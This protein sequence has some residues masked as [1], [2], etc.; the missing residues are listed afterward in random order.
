M[1]WSH[2]IISRLCIPCSQKKLKAQDGKSYAAENWTVHGHPFQHMNIFFQQDFYL[3]HFRST[4]LFSCFDFLPSF[5]LTF[6]F[7]PP[8]ISNKRK[9]YAVFYVG[10]LLIIQKRK[11]I[12]KSVE[13]PF[14]FLYPLLMSGLQTVLF[15]IYFVLPSLQGQSIVC[16]VRSLICLF[17]IL[18]RPCLFCSGTTWGTTQGQHQ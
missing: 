6:L 3:L 9:Q 5:L 12:W 8:K 14:Y 15:Q 16:G 11:K 4:T 10:S 18:L 1:H 2:H 17:K 13:S 7:G